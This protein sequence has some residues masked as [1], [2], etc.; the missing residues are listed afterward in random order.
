[1]LGHIPVKTTI[2]EDLSGISPEIA[3]ELNGLTIWISHFASGCRNLFRKYDDEF[4][5]LSEKPQTTS[6]SVQWIMSLIDFCNT[7]TKSESNPA[8][9]KPFYFEPQSK[10]FREILTEIESAFDDKL[11]ELSNRCGRSMT[12]T[13][14]NT[15]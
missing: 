8:G 9:H 4:E 1:M 5:S 14:K 7:T 6:F 2:S 13:G 11:I 15:R 12:R 3:G 10:H